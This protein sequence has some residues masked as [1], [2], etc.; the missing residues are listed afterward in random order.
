MITARTQ[1]GY[2]KGTL[3]Q[4]DKARTDGKGQVAV[5][6]INIT[7]ISKGMRMSPVYGEDV[8]WRG[9]LYRLHEQAKGM[10]N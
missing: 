6:E 4:Q 3:P 1:V 5:M 2:S 9:M 7:T 10:H 8:L